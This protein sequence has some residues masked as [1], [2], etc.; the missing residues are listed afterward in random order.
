MNKIYLFSP[1][2]FS[3]NQGCGL[4]ARTSEKMHY[5][6]AWIND[7]YNKFL[8]L[9]SKLTKTSI[10]IPRYMWIIDFVRSLIS[11]LQ[12]LVHCILSCLAIIRLEKTEFGYWPFVK[13]LTHSETVRQ[14][15]SHPQVTTEL[16]KGVYMELKAYSNCFFSLS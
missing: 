11:T 16:D 4:S 15:V 9:C 13:E 12:F 14:I 5:K 7:T 8:N 3:S 1:I 2:F 6:F 10:K